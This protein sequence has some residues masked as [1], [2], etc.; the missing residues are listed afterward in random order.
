MPRSLF[1]GL[2]VICLSAG[3]VDAQA[4]GISYVRGT[5]QMGQQIVSIVPIE[6][7]VYDKDG[8][9]VAD[10]PVTFTVKQGVPPFVFPQPETVLSD[11]NGIAV[12]YMPPYA[13]D[14]SLSFSLVEVDAT[15]VAGNPV[16]FLF[17]SM[18]TTPLIQLLSADD[19]LGIVINTTAG[20]LIPGA[21]RISIAA[22]S[23]PQAGQAIPN[24]GLRATNQPYL[25]NA[26]ASIISVSPIDPRVPSA[27]CVNSTLSDSSGMATCDLKIGP[28][29]GTTQLY[30]A[31]GEYRFM[32]VITLN[33]AVG[34]PAQ[35]S[36]ISGSVGHPLTVQ[37]T[38][39]SGNPVEG[40]SIVWTVT[41]GA[42]S[43]GA[44]PTVTDAQGESSNTVTFG[45]TPGPVMIRAQ[46]SASSYVDFYLVS[47]QVVSGVTVVSGDNQSALPGAAFANPLVVRVTDASG[48]PMAGVSVAFSIAGGGSLSAPSVMTDA[49]G[50]AKVTATA[51]PDPG[52]LTVT[53]A[54]SGFQAVFGNLTVVMPGPELSASGIRNA[55][56][57]ARGLTPCGLAVLTG[58]G[59]A[60]GVSGTIRSTDPSA[61]SLGPVDQVLIAGVAA[62]IV[63]V[64]DKRLVVET[65]CATPV[66]E[67]EVEV[68]IQGQAASATGVRVHKF[69]PGLF[70]DADSTGIAQRLVR[71][72]HKDGSAVNVTSPAARG[73]V[74][75]IFATGLGPVND[76]ATRVASLATNLILGIDNAGVP[77]VGSGYL[78]DRPG[79]YFVEVAIPANLVTGETRAAFVIG[80]DRLGTG[81]DLVYSNTAAIPIR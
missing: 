17:T 36:L 55:A 70:T 66:G 38:D 51:G 28:R 15:G 23:G 54:A 80:V 26:A 69:Q 46:M 50:A 48:N 81:L 45:K 47:P 67:A 31:V 12:S 29:A 32:P 72:I 34:P 75:R 71:A 79:M 64:S 61:T 52:A 60:P 73:E 53:A 42:A 25:Y 10:S 56:S 2:A 6:V 43:L 68:S 20:A 39:A 16:K 1:V 7:F 8:N 30:M 49:T 18:A 40:V 74:I 76:A 37:A 14:P 78:T 13:V 65:P 77:V 11:A 57:G 44:N 19:E 63:E 58:D 5:G 35:L 4:V 27:A 22:A 59:L 3:A 62:R 33:V 21:Y 41:S 24:I 9:P